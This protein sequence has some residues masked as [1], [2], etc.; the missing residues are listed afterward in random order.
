MSQENVD[1][2][3]RSLD[4]W[5]RGDVNAWLESAH[6]DI[7]WFSDIA[8]QM[9]GSDSVSRG[10]AAMRRY[11]DEWHSIW[12]LTV[13]VGEIR[14][15][16]DTI[17]ALGRLRTRGDASG[18]DLERPVAYIYEFE[19]GLARKVRSYLDPRDALEA[20]GLSE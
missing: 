20:L 5:N 12:D 4:G 3:R 13:E 11:W 15:L 14:D 17:L 10:P 16:G 6:P 18:I 19:G 8:R 7:E 2:V 9:E 1:L